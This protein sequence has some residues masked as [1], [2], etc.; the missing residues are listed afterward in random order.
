MGRIIG[1]DLGTTNSE[2]AFVDESG[3]AKII[4]SAEGSAYGGKMF[5]SVVAFTKDGQRLVGVAAKR[6]AVVNPEGTVREAKR[7]M[8]SPEKIYVKTVDKNFTPQ[9]ISSMIL[10]KI[11]ADAEAY[12]GEGVD[13]AVITVPAY[14]DDNQRQATKDA[15]E[16][17]GFVVKRIINEPTAAAMAYGLGKGGEYKVAVLDFGG[18]TF[19]VTIMD[20]GEGVFEVLSTSGDTHLGG[21]DMDTA[22]ID[23]LIKGFKD[24]ERVDLSGD[25]TATQRIRDE[26]ERAKIELSSSVSTTIN[27]PFIAV[28]GGEPKHLEVTLTRAKLEELAAPTLKRLEHPIRSA[29]GD[30][31]LSP[32]D[33][34]KIILIGGPTRMPI[35]KERFERILGKKTEGGVDPMQSVARGAAVQAGILT[36]EVKEEIVLLDVTPLTLSIETLGGVATTLI[37]RNTTIP[38][39]KSQVFTT[40]AENQ[41][42][43]EIH[44]SQGER[45]MAVDN[46]SLGRFH[47]DGIPPAPRGIPQIE[48]TFDIDTNGILNVTAKDRG[49]GKEA[50]I[51]IT[52]STKLANEDIDR[53][54]KESEKY[55]EEDKKRKEE[56]ELVNQADSLVY[57]SEKTISELGDKISKEQKENVERAKDKLKESLKVQDMAKIKTDL[58]E[59]TKA[60][61]EV[62]AV[63][64]QEAQKMAAE[65]AAKQEGEEKGKEEKKGEGEGDYVDVDYDVTGEGEKK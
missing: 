27:L 13:A 3:D 59:L 29:L 28:V 45:P 53:M 6:Q 63:V 33:I 36:G 60:L 1:I 20:V 18:G 24:K 43:V 46:T 50:S 52:A 10:Q 9:E 4:P 40:A 8:G 57:T 37:E 49:T 39:K 41:T 47:L 5:P 25:L 61:H 7:R 26:A 34:D 17:A 14:F 23:W 62:S 64:Y 42:S 11:K 38:T 19:D 30:A 44:V 32:G 31:K 21:T 56:V 22:V 65:E 15:G 55:S 54:V 2:A 58:D 35:V 48:V 16:I 51:R 12:L